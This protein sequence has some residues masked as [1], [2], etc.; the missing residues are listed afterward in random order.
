MAL[1]FEFWGVTDTRLFYLFLIIV[2]FFLSK[3]VIFKKKS[4]ESK[5]LGCWSSGVKLAHDICLYWA[6]A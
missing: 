2:L 6:N 4:R 3:R 5:G 1:K